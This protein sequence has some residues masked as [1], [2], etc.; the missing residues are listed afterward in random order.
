MSL[1]P[2]IILRHG[3]TE[4]NVEGRVQGRQD[5]PLT[6]LGRQQAT[7]QGRL[8]QPLLESYPDARIVCS[9][10]GRTRATATIVLRGITKPMTLDVR[11]QEVSAGE[12]EGITREV[13][14]SEFGDEAG[15]K[16]EFDLFTKAPGGETEAQLQARCQAFL[17][18]QTGPVV[19]ITHGVTSLMLRGLA[20]GMTSDEMAELP[21]KQG[22]IYLVE[23][24]EETCLREDAE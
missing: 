22:C 16:T 20:Q 4:W 10:L 24:G 11:L 13:I 12:W 15:L 23:N 19:A 6:E 5:S 21:R 9:P 7:A 3:Q 18:D 14:F 1:P 8:L 17:D 2:L